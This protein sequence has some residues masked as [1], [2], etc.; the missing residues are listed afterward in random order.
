MQKKL[1]VVG[2]LI[3]SVFGVGASA[4]IINCSFTEPFYTTTYSMVQQSLTVK[5]IEGNVSVIPN[6]SFQ[7]M[8]PAHFELWDADRNVLQVLMLNYSGS[9]G[10]SDNIYPYDVKSSGKVYNPGANGGIGGCT[11][12]FLLIPPNPEPGN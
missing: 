4:D 12:N 1:M 9:D 3:A 6:V 10:M 7:I 5:D 2:M 11:S 8:G